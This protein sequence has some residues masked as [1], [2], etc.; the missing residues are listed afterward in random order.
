MNSNEKDV[1]GWRHDWCESP[2]G[3]QED[4]KTDR[5]DQPG[6]DELIPHMNR[7]RTVRLGSGWLIRSLIR[8]SRRTVRC[9]CREQRSQEAA[10]R[11]SIAVVVRIRREQQ[12]ADGQDYKGCSPTTTSTPSL[13]C[14][15]PFHRIPLSNGEID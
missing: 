5:Q 3:L 10:E 12:E 13:N 4:G 11:E 1:P 6:G 9:R 8:M 14:L 7:T 2:F 15:A